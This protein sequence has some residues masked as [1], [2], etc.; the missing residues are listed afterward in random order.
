VNRNNPG[1]TKSSEPTDQ[2]RLK[3]ITPGILKVQTETNSQLLLQEVHKVPKKF[4][5][6]S[7]QEQLVEERLSLLPRTQTLHDT[8]YDL[9]DH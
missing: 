3:I 7:Q 5:I 1:T 6:G 8:F 4:P 2:R 9:I